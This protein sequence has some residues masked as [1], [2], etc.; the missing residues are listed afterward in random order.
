MPTTWKLTLGSG[1]FFQ[2]INFKTNRT[3]SISLKASG[4]G[5][6]T[7]ELEINFLSN[8]RGV[9]Q[10]SKLVTVKLTHDGHFPRL[11]IWKKFAIK[12]PFPEFR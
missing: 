5:S 12:T 3:K 10:E 4:D 9:T 2:D 7:P 11:F 1:G 8:F 6:N